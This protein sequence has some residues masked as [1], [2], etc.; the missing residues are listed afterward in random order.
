MKYALI[1]AVA[2][3]GVATSPA[4]AD[5]FIFTFTDTISSATTPGIS[6]GDTF[7]LVL[8]ADNGSTTA[9][10][11]TWNL[12][13]LQGFSITA[14]SYSA[15]Y[16]KVFEFPATGN[17]VTD[18]AGVLTS[19]QFYGTS[20]LSNNTDNFGSWT[21]D[22]VFGDAFFDDYF[23]RRNQVAAGGFNNPASWTVAPGG[24]PEPASWALMIGGFGAVGVL[25]RRQRRAVAA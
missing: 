25:A 3:V 22:T 14:G 17:F 4:L 19:I 11:Q 2:L 5:P 18:A 10:S 1:A 16:S 12:A 21:A 6:V 13:D 15:T 24:V 9:A 8:H 23:G 20:T 7:T